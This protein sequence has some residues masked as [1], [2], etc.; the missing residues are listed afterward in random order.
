MDYFLRLYDI[1]NWKDYI[2]KSFQQQID[3][4]I[5]VIII[6]CLFKLHPKDLLLTNDSIH[7]IKN[8]FFQLKICDKNIKEQELIKLIGVYAN[9]YINNPNEKL[10]I[11]KLK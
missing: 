8:T 5:N 4:N 9:K 10:L 6:A 2:I 1:N 7:E 11:S 3:N